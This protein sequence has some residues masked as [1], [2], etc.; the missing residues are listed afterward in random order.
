MIE[1]EQ[2]RLGIEH[3]LFNLKFQQSQ[4]YIFVSVCM[5]EIEQARLG[6]EH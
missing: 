3:W 2:A 5:I 1:I 6:I 4:F